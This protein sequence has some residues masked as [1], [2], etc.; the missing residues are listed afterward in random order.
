M[1]MCITKFHLCSSIKGADVL[2]KI[3]YKEVSALDLW[4][5]VILLGFCCGDFQDVLGDFVFIAIRQ[6]LPPPGTH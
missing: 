4:I 6:C 3:Y 2:N 5:L 1:R